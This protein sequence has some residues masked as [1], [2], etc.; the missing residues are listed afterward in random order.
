[1]LLGEEIQDKNVIFHPFACKS[2]HSAL[3]SFLAMSS[4]LVCIPTK[5]VDRIR[6]YK[7][8]LVT[9]SFSFIIFKEMNGVYR[10]FLPDT[11]FSEFTQINLTITP[12]TK[13][14]IFIDPT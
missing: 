6:M 12:A 9:C 2:I 10:S 14:R 3:P 11:S 7:F 1:M 5:A 8:K 4:L 13:L